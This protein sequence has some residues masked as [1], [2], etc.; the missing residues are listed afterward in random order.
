MYYYYIGIINSELGQWDL[1]EKNLR[2]ALEDSTYFAAGAPYLLTVLT[3]KQKWADAVEVGIAYSQSIRDTSAAL[4]G[5][6]GL[7]AGNTK[8]WVI[9]E[10]ALKKAI[11]L[12]PGNAAFKRDLG[13]TY[14]LKGEPEKAI[15]LLQVIQNA[16]D[17][18]EE[19]RIE[20]RANLAAA[21]RKLR[22]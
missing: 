4:L 7:W 5:G 11:F 2:R 21:E 13:I 12:K 3:E 17:L 6:I 22:K 16:P 9:A 1:A 10:A 19:A 20:V 18:T 15:P 14:I 8:D